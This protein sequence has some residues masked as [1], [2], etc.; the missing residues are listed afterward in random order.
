MATLYFQ[1]IE[2]RR[3]RVSLRAHSTFDAG[4]QDGQEPGVDVRSLFILH[5]A[6][7][8]RAAAL[9]GSLLAAIVLA[10]GGCASTSAKPA[11]R[12]TADLVQARTGDRITWN[13][14]GANDAAVAIEVR[15]LLAGALTVD[16]A[17]Q[18]A[19]LRNKTLQATYEDLSVAQADLVQAGLL[20]NPVFG[21]GVAFPIAG[22]AQTGVT[23]SVSQD[24][25]GVFALA[26]RKKVARAELLATEL[27][28]GDAVLRMTYEVECAY[29]DLVAEQQTA[30]M[31]RTVLD[32]GDAAI[33]L[34]RRQ[35]EA[36]NIS[37]LD[38]ASEEAL[39]EDVRTDVL[40]SEAAVLK[41]REALTRL[42]GVWDIDLEH[43]V[44]TKLP[45][46]P[47]GDTELPELESLAVAR[48]LDVSA[49][50]QD[51]EVFSNAID[52]AKTNRWIGSSSVGA[53]YERAPEGFTAVGPN[54]GLE[55]PIFDQ[56]Q[57]PLARLEGRLRAARAR[58][59]ALT[60]AVRSE[61]R[62]ARGRLSA[63]RAVALR[64]AN[65]VVPLRERVVA[66]A[67]QHYNAMLLGT[68]Q[69]LQAKAREVTAYREL[70]EALR[71]YWTARADLEL[72]TGGNLPMFLPAR[73]AV[74][75]LG[76]QTR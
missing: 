25:L 60:F 56:K 42:I 22:A 31:R 66:L 17:V 13:P 9:R 38:L 7:S 2:P 53:T 39:Y 5:G 24:F 8:R 58:E 4:T 70:I 18:I 16:S 36:G 34:A 72:A 62:V 29:Y 35:H 45:E 23:L 51:A 1:I 15:K 20:Q 49:A 67:Q 19:L 40:R 54:V 71:D 64:Y 26:A 41:A 11:F 48:R 27:R 6:T 47:P 76:R 50:R 74:P 63:A 75:S 44:A 43:R 46:L 68:A 59:E 73:N 52:L 55:L 61:V 12:D 14:G 57:A 10:L 28:V 32:V 21:A 37:E 33:D 30:A 69:L 65:V 3:A